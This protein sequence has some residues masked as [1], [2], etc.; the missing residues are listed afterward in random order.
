MYDKQHEPSWQ[1]LFALLHLD[2]IQ[3]HSKMPFPPRTTGT[4]IQAL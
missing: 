1:M 2:A 4:P 3:S